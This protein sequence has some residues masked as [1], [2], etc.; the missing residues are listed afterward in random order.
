MIKMKIMLEKVMTKVGT[1]SVQ[2]SMEL[3][4][5]RKHHRKRMR[6]QR[7]VEVKKKKI[8]RKPWRL[9]MMTMTMKQESKD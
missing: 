3:K 9:R 2:I 5:I 6:S 1:T 7:K 8:N 4:S